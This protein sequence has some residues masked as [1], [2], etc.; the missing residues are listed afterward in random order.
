MIVPDYQQVL[1][2]CGIPPGRIIV[3]AAIA[4]VQTVNDSQAKWRTTLDHPAA[5]GVYMVTLR[6]NED[7]EGRRVWGSGTGGLGPLRFL[8]PTNATLTPLV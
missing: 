3:N 1:A 7:G 8:V 6:E 2:G 5:H 4:H